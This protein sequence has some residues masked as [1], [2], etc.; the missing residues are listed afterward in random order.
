MVIEAEHIKTKE[1]IQKLKNIILLI[2]KEK[3]DI[4]YELHENFCQSISASLLHINMAQRNVTEKE[5]TYLEEA[6]YILQEVLSGLRSIAN[7]ISPITLKLLGFVS[8][9]HSLCNLIKEQKEID[10]L[11][12]IDESCINT[13][14]LH[15]QNTLYQVTQL[16]VI[17]IIKCAD[18]K[19]VEINILP[20]GDKVKMEIRNDGFCEKE[21]SHINSAGFKTLTET[22]EAFEGNFNFK[23]QDNNLGMIIEVCI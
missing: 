6:A 5:L 23:I 3:D 4:G 14:S 18:V 15:F 10:C 1:Q 13:L 9:I 21:H 20:S 11:I 16:Q 22:I 2:E 17:N 8:M 19:N 7:N 12:T